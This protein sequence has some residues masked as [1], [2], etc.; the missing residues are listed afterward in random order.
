MSDEEAETAY[1]ERF[2]AFRAGRASRDD[3]LAAL[4]ERVA[5]L[6][7]AMER[8]TRY[9]SRVPFPKAEKLLETLSDPPSTVLAAVRRETAAQAR[10]EALKEAAD[11]I[12][13]VE[14]E[15]RPDDYHKPDLIWVTDAQR[16]IR[17]L[18]GDNTNE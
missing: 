16:A 9:V 4:R 11:A 13:R 7:A 12:G 2:D 17:A 10:E 5:E 14:I 18:E 3:E 8:A 6:E 1:T 15:E